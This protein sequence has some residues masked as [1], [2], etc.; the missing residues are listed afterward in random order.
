MRYTLFET[1]GTFDLRSITT[2]GMSV[3]PKAD[4]PIGRFGS[5][6][7]YAIAVLLREGAKI[8]LHCNGDHYTFYTSGEKF[9]GEVFERC[10]YKRENG[11]LK[12]FSGA[13]LP[14]T[15]EYGQFWE[16]W[17]A[18]RELYANT[19]DEGG[20]VCNLT[21]E[22]VEEIQYDEGK[23]YILVDHQEFALWVPRRNEIFLD[24]HRD[25]V[26]DKGEGNITKGK[27]KHVY[28][29]GMRAL[30]LPE[31]KPAM[32]TYNVIE[33]VDLTED[34]TIKNQYEAKRVIR[35]L[36]TQSEDKSFIKAVLTAP[37]NTFE[38]DFDFHYVYGASDTFN[39]AV[40]ELRDHHSLNA[41]ARTYY[42][43]SIAPPARKLIEDQQWQ[44]IL[45]ALEAG[46]TQVSEDI[47]LSPEESDEVH[48]LYLYEMQ[49]KF[50][51]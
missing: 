14:Y 8:Q 25:L 23:T 19:L 45:D 28:F 36:V 40:T 48:A 30:D 49:R 21:L 26:V 15:T 10:M 39:K 11:L 13:E 3:K 12:I 27:S 2:M 41:S 33:D 37:D 29:R 32:F 44:M 38:K 16:L 1:P 35:D 7:K 6:L 22:E 50:N 47:K 34:R 31:D 24:P 5:G 46:K 17:M 4:N 43:T 20:I 51:R 9:R 42:S 18:F